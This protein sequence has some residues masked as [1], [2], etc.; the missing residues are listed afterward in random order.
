MTLTHKEELLKFFLA[1]YVHLSKKDYG[2]FNNIKSLIEDNKPFTSNQ[3]K[4]FDKLVVKYQRQLAKNNIDTETLLNL[5]WNATIVESAPSYLQAKISCFANNIIIKTPFNSKFVTDFRK[6]QL[7]SF[8]WDKNERQ[9]IAPFSTYNL[10]LAVNFVGKYFKDVVFC[11][12]IQEHIDKLKVYDSA[13]IWSPTLIKINDQY[14]IASINEN[15]Y[16]ATKNLILSNNCKV[17]FELSKYG[18][19][20]SNEIIG[21]D[22]QLYI[23]SNYNVTM[24][25]D[26]LDDLVNI[27]KKL[28]ILTVFTSREIIHNREITNEIKKALLEQGIV[29]KPYNFQDNIKSGI[30]IKSTAGTMHSMPDVDKIITITNSRPINIR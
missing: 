20:I 17:L 10:H 23:A 25:L 9:Y 19:K 14:Y 6:I 30:L 18:I 22:Q 1:G 27:L 24:D 4:L 15:L 28:D 13:N 21:N 29:C 3:A 2:F 5:S 12:L 7:N 16:D 26:N 8:I 11:D